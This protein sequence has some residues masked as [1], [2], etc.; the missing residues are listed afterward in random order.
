MEYKHI[1]LF[2]GSSI[3]LTSTDRQI[4]N[5]IVDCLKKHE[6]N[7]ATLTEIYDYVKKNYPNVLNNIHIKYCILILHIKDRVSISNRKINK[8]Y[9][10]TN[11]KTFVR[12]LD[13]DRPTQ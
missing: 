11:W 12:L 4:I 8:K 7:K 3:C 6:K 13:R 1:K 10:R 2:R 9:S 5:L